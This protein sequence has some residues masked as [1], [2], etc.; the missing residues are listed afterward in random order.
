MFEEELLDSIM[1][2][3]EARYRVRKDPAHRAIAGLSMGGGQSLNVGL[4]HTDM[5]GYIG[6]M[7]S[8][9]SEEFEQSFSAVLG[10]SKDLNKKLGLF[11]IGMGKSD[12][13]LANAERL[14][15]VLTRHGVRHVYTKT[16]GA[17]T[18]RVW[19]HYLAELLPMLFRGNGS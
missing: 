2:A 1:P 6:V 10:N 3:V 14:D 8:G 4:R 9:A 13:G 16:E 11:W 15:E 17:H 5:F 7:S 19:R 12:P 18:W